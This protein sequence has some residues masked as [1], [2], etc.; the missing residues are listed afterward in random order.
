[1]NKFTGKSLKYEFTF[2]KYKGCTLEEVMRA[3]VDYITWLIENAQFKMDDVSFDFYI[4]KKDDKD[5]F[6]AKRR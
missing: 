1:M 6:P 4:R 2:G 5:S 3:D